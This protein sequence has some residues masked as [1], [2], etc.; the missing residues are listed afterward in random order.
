MEKTKKKIIKKKSKKMTEKKLKK[1]K[2]NEDKGGQVAQKLSKNK[3]KELQETIKKMHF[4]EFSRK[5]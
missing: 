2:Q 3:I 4:K 5:I 1:E